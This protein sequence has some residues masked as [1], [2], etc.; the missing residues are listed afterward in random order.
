MAEQLPPY[1]KINGRRVQRDSKGDIVYVNH[2]RELKDIQDE[3]EK[4][5]YGHKHPKTAAAWAKYAS[6][7]IS[8]SKRKNATPLI[9]KAAIITVVLLVAFAIFKSKEY[10]GITLF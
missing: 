4:Q 2:F 9:E 6:M 5:G 3:M 8:Y 10:F 7:V 1:P